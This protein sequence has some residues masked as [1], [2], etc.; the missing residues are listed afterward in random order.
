MIMTLIKE[1]LRDLNVSSIGV[2]LILNEKEL[3]V[4]QN[5]ND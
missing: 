3:S 4:C 2:K 5:I 1:N